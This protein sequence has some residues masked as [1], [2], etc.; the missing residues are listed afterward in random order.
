MIIIITSL[1]EHINPLCRRSSSDQEYC[2]VYCVLYLFMQACTNKYN[3]R[4][5]FVKHAT[6]N[7][8]NHLNI[9]NLSRK[10]FFIKISFVNMHVSLGGPVSV[11][12]SSHSFFYTL[13]RQ[14][15]EFVTQIYDCAW[16]S[17]HV[18]HSSYL[19][20]IYVCTADC[21][22]IPVQYWCTIR[23]GKQD[24]EKK[25]YY[26]IYVYVAFTTR[27]YGGGG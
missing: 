10:I 26:N 17:H 27:G 25:L 20:I 13:A 3:K 19:Y 5:R 7:V 16:A 14:I 23:F 8:Y 11:S 22:N 18:D 1:P 12:F 15:F 21:F 9:I 2:A 24:F 4:E 6:R